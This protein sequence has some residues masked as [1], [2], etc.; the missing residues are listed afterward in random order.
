MGVDIYILLFIVLLIVLLYIVLGTTKSTVNTKSE[1]R[2]FLRVNN[3]CAQVDCTVDGSNCFSDKQKCLQKTIQPPKTQETFL[4]VNNQCVQ[5]DCT[6]DDSNCFSD[7]QKCLQKTIQPPKSQDTFLRVNNQCVQVNCTV[8]DSNCFSDKQKCFISGLPKNKYTATEDDQKSGVIQPFYVAGNPFYN[9]LSAGK[10]SWKKYIHEINDLKKVLNPTVIGIADDY[11]VGWCGADSD[12]SFMLPNGDVIMTFGDSYLN[13]ID[14]PNIWTAYR[15]ADGISMPHNSI[16]YWSKSTGA[17]YYYCG[18]SP[19]F[20]TYPTEDICPTDLPAKNFSDMEAFYKQIPW[21]GEPTGCS[22]L[23]QPKTDLSIK[24]AW[25]YGGMTNYSGN[26]SL[27]SSV[28][29]G[30]DI[31]KN[32][33]VEV[34]NAFD[35]SGLKLNPFL[36]D[37]NSVKVDFPQIIQ[38]LNTFNVASITYEKIFKDET[39]DSYVLVGCE[40]KKPFG[41]SLY[42]VK[43][44]YDELINWKNFKIWNGTNWEMISDPQSSNS[45]LFPIVIK[46]DKL[47]GGSNVSE[48]YYIRDEKSY[49]FFSLGSNFDKNG[50]KKWCIFKY[51]SISKKLEGPYD[52]DNTFEYFLPD[53]VNDN[54]TYYNVYALRVHQAL[55]SKVSDPTGKLECIISYVAQAVFPTHSSLSFAEGSA[56]YNYY[57]QF[58][59]IYKN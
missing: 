3:Q 34:K 50:V 52:I 47:F 42:I 54:P 2:T 5:V 22:S 25:L 41:T 11:G 43:G 30:G 8:D 20:L 55:L 23:I 21:W 16:S 40:N 19:Y 51:K 37:K 1:T 13:F 32:Q 48:I 49:G 59:M 12:G 45:V 7:K 28:I 57:P 18:S 4:R 29:Y 44:S 33:F 39:D 24:I 31:Y 38:P 58:I 35:N 10:Y 36:W 27:L 56:F 26:L 46:N 6:I 14:S 53:W 9:S 17:N 15:K